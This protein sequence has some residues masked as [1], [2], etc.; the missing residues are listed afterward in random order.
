MST[1]LFIAG[2]ILIAALVICIT[3]SHIKYSRRRKNE[4][5]CVKV[6]K[7]SR[8]AILNLI[9]AVIWVFIAGTYIYFAADKIQEIDSG[10]WDDIRRPAAQ[11]VEEHRK[12]LRSKEEVT[13][14]WYSLLLVFW[15]FSGIIQTLELTVFKYEYITPKGVYYPDSFKPSE[16][17]TYEFSGDTLLL[18]YKQRQTP[19]KHPVPESED[20]E[21]LRQILNDNYKLH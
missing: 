14:R 8:A 16:N 18:Y 21:L 13:I 12:I 1:I 20:K 7:G 17:F 2:W 5:T 10:R 19:A 9:C 11:T 15:M 3:F 4:P 6:L